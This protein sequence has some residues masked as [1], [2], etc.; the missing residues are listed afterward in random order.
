MYAEDS[1]FTELEFRLLLFDVS[2]SL[3]VSFCHTADPH[4]TALLI[5]AATQVDLFPFGVVVAPSLSLSRLLCPLRRLR[6]KVHYM[7]HRDWNH[8]VRC[9]NGNIN[10]VGWDFVLQEAIICYTVTMMQSPTA[11]STLVMYAAN[12]YCPKSSHYDS[13][14]FRKNLTNTTIRNKY[15]AEYSGKDHLLHPPNT[16]VKARL[17][18]TETDPSDTF[19]Y[20]TPTENEL[21]Y[22]RRQFRNNGNSMFSHSDICKFIK[23]A[24]QFYVQKIVDSQDGLDVFTLKRN[25]I[26]EYSGNAR[27]TNPPNTVADL[28]LSY[29]ETEPDQAILHEHSTT[30]QFVK[31][32]DCFTNNVYYDALLTHAKVSYSLLSHANNQ[33]HKCTREHNVESI[34]E[35]CRLPFYDY[36]LSSKPRLD[37]RLRH[38]L[39]IGSGILLFRFR[40]CYSHISVWGLR[41]GKHKYFC[42]KGRKAMH[43]AQ[44]CL[45]SALNGEPGKHT[46]E[47]ASLSQLH[48]CESDVCANGTPGSSGGKNKR[49]SSRRN[50]RRWKCSLREYSTRVSAVFSRPPLRLNSCP[51]V[52]I[53]RDVST[54]SLCSKQQSEF[55]ATSNRSYTWTRV[56]CNVFRTFS[57]PHCKK[58]LKL[59]MPKQYPWKFATLNVEDLRSTITYMRIKQLFVDHALDVLAIQETHTIHNDYYCKDGLHYFLM[60]G[61]NDKHAGVGFVVSPKVFPFVYNFKPFSARIAS[62]NIRTSGK[63]LV[64]FSVYAP[65]LMSHIHSHEDDLERKQE[66]WDLLSFSI[67]DARFH[68]T[69]ILGDLNMRYHTPVPEMQHILGPH[70]FGHKPTHDPLYTT[71]LEFFL[72]FA[73]TFDFYLPSTFQTKHPSQRVTYKELS[74]SKLADTRFPFPTDFAVLDHIVVP[75]EC[76]RCMPDVTSITDFS[77]PSHHYPVVLKMNYENRLPVQVHKRDPAPKYLVP[78]KEQ[79]LQYIAA[80]YNKIGLSLKEEPTDDLFV[81]IYT[82]GSFDPS[83]PLSH[84]SPGGWGFCVSAMNDQW[85]DSYGMIILDSDNPAAIGITDISNNTAELQAVIEALDY[86]LRNPP[87]IAYVVYVDSQYTLDLIASLSRPSTHLALVL[88]LQSLSRKVK[89]RQ[90]I[91]FRKVAAHTGVLGNER[92]DMLAARGRLGYE[93]PQTGRFATYPPMPITHAEDFQIPQWFK[94]L[95][96]GEQYNFIKDLFKLAQ[97]FFPTTKLNTANFVLSEDTAETYEAFSALRYDSLSTSKEK[98]RLLSLFRKQV[99]KDKRRYLEDKLLEDSNSGPSQKWATIKTIRKT[100]IPSAPNVRATSGQV[101]SPETRSAFLAQYFSMQVWSGDNQYLPPAP[102]IH[103]V[104]LGNMHPFEIWELYSRISACKNRKAGGTDGI[105]SEFIKYAPQEALLFLLLFFNICFLSTSVPSEWYHSR[106]AAIPKPKSKDPLSVTSFRP[107]CLSQTCYKLYAGML[108]KRL[109]GCIEM[110]IRE[111]QFG[112]RSNRSTSQPIHILRRIIELFERSTTALHLLFLDWKKAFDSVFRSAIAKALYRL[113]VPEPLLNA[114]MSL[115]VESTFE[116]FDKFGSSGKYPQDRGIRQGCPI[117]PY[118]FNIVLTVLLHDVEQDYI[119]LHGSS[120]WVYSANQSMWDVEYADDTVLI[121]RSASSLQVIVNLLIPR[122]LQIGLELNAGKCEHLSLNSDE[123]IHYSSEQTE[124]PFSKVSVAKYLG[125]YLDSSSSSAKEISYRLQQA[126]NAFR[127]LGSF[128]RHRGISVKWRLQVHR[129]VLISILTYALNSAAL[130]EVSLRRLDSFHFKVLRSISGAK[131]TFFSKL[132][133]QSSPVVTMQDLHSVHHSISKTCIPPSQIISAQRMSFFGHILRHPDSIQYTCCLREMGNPRL[134]ST[135]LRKGAPRL[136]WAEMCYVEA[137][138][139]LTLLEHFRLPSQLPLSHVYHSHVCRSE[140]TDLLGGDTIYRPNLTMIT[141]YVRSKAQDRT[142]WKQISRPP[143]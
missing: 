58:R 104:A 43:L 89:L 114:V 86:I 95:S 69:I 76:K 125:V 100:Y 49:S 52:L 40:V 135:T 9:I 45:R 25:H 119:A 124:V 1:F 60:G 108:K 117:S 105:L 56:K 13:K 30:E 109:E 8:F 23:H 122:S 137:Y 113:G 73:E 11:L 120:P 50:Y 142:L 134:L 42:F 123:S 116:I 107:I 84:A 6:M 33:N 7:T 106:L 24:M 97:Q 16:G 46:C 61:I 87:E 15:F 38:P 41:R 91:S 110:R 82:D 130:D 35:C 92:A 65:S 118:I 20:D 141:N 88:K 71:N 18:R 2:C 139:K 59:S 133:D 12:I 128:F 57:D 26:A 5:G 127:L 132:V 115:Y 80:V 64:L 68:T 81:S 62:L 27:L 63:P 79:K 138:R 77:F 55:K 22:K 83:S 94:S 10:S 21:I 103:E 48:S 36:D 54:V 51:K 39:N 101:S 78:N 102:P 111:Y 75:V 31:F 96:F 143:E 4:S 98:K 28:Q 136:H 72:G 121:G 66:F 53:S 131:H 32:S 29:T 90:P 112:F 85:I 93:P 99:K 67:P 14:D 140:V 74:A 47:D 19:H 34:C 70:F 44:H 129:Q 3:A 37:S 126:G 17:S